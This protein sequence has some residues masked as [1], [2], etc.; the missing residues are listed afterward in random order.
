MTAPPF[1]S[2]RW[3]VGETVRAW[4]GLVSESL[5][6]RPPRGLG[7]VLRSS[8]RGSMTRRLPLRTSTGR[9]ILFAWALL[10]FGLQGTAA[11]ARCGGLPLGWQHAPMT[12]VGLQGA[13]GRPVSPLSGGAPLTPRCHGPACS[14][15]PLPSPA[16]VVT[17]PP[18][19][20]KSLL[21]PSVTLPGSGGT[22]WLAI[23]SV[24]LPSLRLPGGTFRPPRCESA[25]V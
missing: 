13:L 4:T 5:F 11:H 9:A 7:S 25:G 17:A 20:A 21:A 2:Q 22:E 8:M 14:G 10:T 23:E 18:N 12:E 3:P 24:R 16:P 19:P 6:L 1:P 15:A